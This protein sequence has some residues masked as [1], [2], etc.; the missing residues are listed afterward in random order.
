MNN[1]LGRSI[2]TLG[3]HAELMDLP[4]DKKRDIALAIDQKKKIRIP[5]NFPS[6][7]L[8]S[9][10]V[11]IFNEIYY[12]IG[13]KKQGNALVDLNSYFYPLD[14]I[15]DWNKIYGQRG[16]AQFQCIIPLKNASKGMCELLE[17]VSL[18]Q[19]SSFLA[20]LK[21]FGK[22]ES[23]ISFPMEGYTLALDFPITTKNLE[24]MRTLDEITLKYGG[25][26]YLTK[27]SRMTAEVFKRSDSRLDGFREF[28]GREAN[29]SFSSV[30]SERL[31]L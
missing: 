29:N 30:Q 26:F 18:A 14:S 24:L 12:W 2:I 19:A 11:K 5:F 28:K 20:V 27:D 15:L 21:R 22:Q 4:A 23:F 16:F 8:N 13:T 9:L 6:F 7:I 10:T 3:E 17:T 31:G 25:R 1:K